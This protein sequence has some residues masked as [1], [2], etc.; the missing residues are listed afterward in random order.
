MKLC[1]SW[2]ADHLFPSNRVTIYPLPHPTSTTSDSGGIWTSTQPKITPQSRLLPAADSVVPLHVASSPGSNS[3]RALFVVF[4]DVIVASCWMWP[5]KRYQLICM[6]VAVYWVL[7]VH[8]TERTYWPASLAIS[9]C[10]LSFESG[11]LTRR[12]MVN[13]GN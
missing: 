5:V 1:S 12:P 6:Y 11:H 3:G 13:T 8:G 2:K 9:C 10:L 7:C 4:N